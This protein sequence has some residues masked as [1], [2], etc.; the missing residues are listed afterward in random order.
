MFLGHCPSCIMTE[1]RVK[2]LKLPGCG[3]GC[4][5]H[6]S[7]FCWWM[8]E[9][10]LTATDFDKISRGLIWAA[11]TLRH[12]DLPQWNFRYLDIWCYSICIYISN[13][14]TRFVNWNKV[15]QG[16][17]SLVILVYIFFRTFTVS[18]S[19]I[20]VYLPNLFL[21]EVLFFSHLTAA[22]GCRD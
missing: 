22:R 18:K 13:L 16:C 20:L 15:C 1:L 2:T 14:W 7:F 19:I 17:L 11:T 6:P 12:L 4:F 8:L 10:Y 3:G 21:G 9:I 5:I